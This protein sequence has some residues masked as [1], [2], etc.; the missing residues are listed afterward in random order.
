MAL[1]LFWKK[2]N[3]H[4]QKLGSSAMEGIYY[5]YTPFSGGEKR[6]PIETFH[7]KLCWTVNIFYQP[8]DW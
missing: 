7:H 3:T 1:W 2:K 5:V 8:Y 6:K 4:T